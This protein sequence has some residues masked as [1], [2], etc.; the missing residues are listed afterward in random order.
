MVF[1]N[2]KVYQ[3]WCV[4]CGSRGFD[5][6]KIKVNNTR[7]LGPVAHSSGRLR[8]LVASVAVGVRRVAAAGG[9]VSGLDLCLSLL[10]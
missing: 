1:I 9:K 5:P 4:E 6:H 10:A 8:R 3:Y 7:W 2:I